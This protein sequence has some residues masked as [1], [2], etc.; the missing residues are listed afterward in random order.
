M[1]GTKIKKTD[2]RATIAASDDLVVDR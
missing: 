1:S 2:L